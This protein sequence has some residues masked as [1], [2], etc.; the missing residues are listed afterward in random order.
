MKKQAARFA[1]GLAV[2]LVAVLGGKVPASAGAAPGVSPDT[3]ITAAIP[4]VAAKSKPVNKKVL[5]GKPAKTGGI[6]P[7]SQPACSTP[8]CYLYAGSSQN[9]MTTDGISATLAVRNPYAQGDDHSLAELTTQDGSNNIVELGWNRDF[10]LYSDNLTHLFVGSWTGGTFNGYNGGGYLDAGGCAPCAGDALT[11]DLGTSQNFAMQHLTTVQCGCATAGWW[12]GYKASWIGVFPDTMWTSPAFTQGTLVQ[13]FG[14][15]ASLDTSAP[16]TD[17][18]NGIMPGGGAAGMNGIALINGSVGTNL[19]NIIQTNS[20]RYAASNSTGTAMGYGGP[21]WDSIGVG[22]GVTSHC[23]P[24]TAGTCATT[25]CA[26]QEICPDGS[27]TGCNLGFST[28]ASMAIGGTTAISGIQ[29][30]AWTNTSLTGKAWDAYHT[31]ACS[32][33]STFRFNANTSGKTT[34]GSWD[35]TQIHCIKRV[36]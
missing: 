9:S 19:S 13:A 5:K 18:G 11:A 2:V 35:D 17:M 8:P 14:E 26:W 4:A 36:A 1:V 21:G 16:C 30:N 33:G 31:T 28:A 20:A 6:S 27:S 34:V 3:H 10:L 29:W 24:N 23:A 22:L 25:L 7:L 32:P 12:V 15:I